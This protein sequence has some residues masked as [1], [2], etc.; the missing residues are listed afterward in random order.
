MCKLLGTGYNFSLSQQQHWL[1]Q[2]YTKKE[3]LNRV[4]ELVEAAPA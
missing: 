1:S 4:E 3:S 2:S